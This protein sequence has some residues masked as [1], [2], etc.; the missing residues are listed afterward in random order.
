[1]KQEE[2]IEKKIKHHTKMLEALKAHKARVTGKKVNK[3]AEKIYKKLND[4][5]FILRKKNKK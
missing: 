3:N 4:Y 5:E 1:M 2:F